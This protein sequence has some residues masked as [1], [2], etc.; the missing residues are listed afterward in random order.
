[1]SIFSDFAAGAAR[2][3]INSTYLQPYGTLTELDIDA[4]QKSA[5][6][7]LEL[8]GE[9]QP[10]EIRIIRYELIERGEDTFI[11]ILEVQTSRAWLNTLLREHLLEKVIQPRLAQTPLPSMA[12]M[13]L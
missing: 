9:V 10:L 6:L 8:K 1:M 4:T 13:L 3:A 5:F 2:A 7:K 12:A 11:N